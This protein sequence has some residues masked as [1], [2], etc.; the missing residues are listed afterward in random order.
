MSAQ[1][2]LTQLAMVK[3][4]ESEREIDSLEKKHQLNGI[5]IEGK[6]LRVGIREKLRDVDVL[7]PNRRVLLIEEV[8]SSERGSQEWSE[9]SSVL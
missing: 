9:N 5:F 4:G 7:A 2:P 1:L 3:E 8:T 6:R